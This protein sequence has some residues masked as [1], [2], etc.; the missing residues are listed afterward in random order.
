MLRAA[1]VC[2]SPCDD[3]RVRISG[4][5][6]NT[7]GI[8][9]RGEEPERAGSRPL[10]LD[11]VRPWLKKWGCDSRKSVQQRSIGARELRDVLRTPVVRSLRRNTKIPPTPARNPTTCAA[12]ATP[13][14]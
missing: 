10:S 3:D 4:L 8:L 6:I 9:Y 12:N 13:R 7:I 11:A 5:P 14:R 2:P 1:I